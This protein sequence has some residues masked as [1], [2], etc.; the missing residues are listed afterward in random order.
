MKLIKIIIVIS[1]LIVGVLFGRYQSFVKEITCSEWGTVNITKWSTL[2]WTLQNMFHQ[3]LLVKVYLKLNPPDFVLQAGRYNLECNT[4]SEA[5]EWFKIPIN[6]TDISLRFLEGWN[7]YD[8]DQYLSWTGLID[9]WDFSNYAKKF[10]WFLYPDTYAINPNNF[11]IQ[12]LV[13]KMRSNFN[14]KTRNIIPH[15]YTEQQI[16]ELLTLASIVQK[17][18]NKA[19]NPAEIAIIAGILKKRLDEWW[20]IGADATVCY[21]HQISTRDCTPQKVLEYL[22]DENSYNTRV[23]AWLPAGPIGNPEDVIIR[24]T[25]NSTSSSYYYYL[26]DNSGQIHYGKTNA[27]HIRNKQLYLR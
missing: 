12:W 23:I 20:M 11:Y 9:I 19:D 14:N 26:H 2:Q 6:D 7:I 21:A 22:Y 3:D 18:A 10:E 13:E 27:E 8:I 16:H 4:I 1:L 15:S 17:E 5:I 24:A 25:L